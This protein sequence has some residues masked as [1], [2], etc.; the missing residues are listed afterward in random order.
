MGER[1]EHL[2]QLETDHAAVHEAFYMFITVQKHLVKRSLA[3][4]NPEHVANKRIDVDDR[5]QAVAT[6]TNNYTRAWTEISGA[7]SRKRQA[8]YQT[9]NR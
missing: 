5:K 7:P 1:N 3:E 6:Q 2:Q 9:S 4:S 8:H